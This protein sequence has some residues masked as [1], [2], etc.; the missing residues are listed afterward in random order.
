MSHIFADPAA[1]GVV[2]GSAWPSP[3]FN[4]LPQRAASLPRSVSTGQLDRTRL[5]TRHRLYLSCCNN[6][7]AILFCPKGYV[8]ADRSLNH[9]CNQFTGFGRIGQRGLG[10]C[11]DCWPNRGCSRLVGRLELTSLYDGNR[12]THRFCND[13]FDL[14]S[15][16]TYRA[17]PRR[18]LKLTH[19][20]ASRRGIVA[21][22]A[23][24]NSSP[25]FF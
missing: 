2:A 6:R 23:I 24:S 17:M 7:F 1:V 9:G 20:P 5:T 15:L 12:S 14:Q 19:L 16:D 22:N 4:S 10:I 13:D 18:S 21:H 11:T 8:R 3:F 25:K